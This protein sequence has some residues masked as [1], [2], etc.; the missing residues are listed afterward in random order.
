MIVREVARPDLTPKPRVPRKAGTLG[1]RLTER[2]LALGLTPKPRFFF[3]A[4]ATTELYTV[5][6]LAALPM[7]RRD[8]GAAGISP[9]RLGH[10]E[11]DDYGN[12]CT[13]WTLAGLAR[14]LDT[15]MDWLWRGD[16]E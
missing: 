16:G 12:L 4:A 9:L 5:R 10:L 13:A 6:L 3:N 14:A 11:R 15:S 8:A 2:R 1:A 7:W